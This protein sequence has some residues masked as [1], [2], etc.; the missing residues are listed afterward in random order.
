VEQF[1]VAMFQNVFDYRT[2]PTVEAIKNVLDWCWTD[3]VELRGGTV[4]G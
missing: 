3:R 1:I 4:K 2:Q